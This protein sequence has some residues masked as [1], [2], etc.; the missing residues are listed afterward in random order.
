MSAQQ[1]SIKIVGQNRKARHD[2]EITDTYEAGMVL[3]GSEVKSLRNGTCSLDEAFA[4]PKGDEL[5]LYDM[6]I[7]PYEQATIQRHEPKRPR[8]LLLHRR[9]LQR[10]IGEC[11]QRGYTLVPLKVYFK[12]GKAKVEI[13]LARR[14][15]KWDKRMKKEAEQRRA[16]AKAD[17]SRRPRR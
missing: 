1:E 7:P 3:V 6:H 11:T 8:K 4:R 13:G 17:L 12:E 15:R 9:E 10:I 2:F 16:D 14:R 5:Y